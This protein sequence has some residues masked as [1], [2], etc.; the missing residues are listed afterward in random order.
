MVNSFTPSFPSSETPSSPS[1]LPSE[2]TV[3]ALYHF[4]HPLMTDARVENLRAEVLSHCQ[5]LNV[6]GTL[7]LAPEGINGT[8]SGS[9]DALAVLADYLLQQDEFTGLEYKTSQ[10]REG[11]A[12]F[13]RMKVKVK[14][15]I[16]S[17]GPRVSPAQRTGEHVDAQRFN[18]LLDDPDVVV[19]DTRNA[20]E[21]EVGTFPGALNPQ[22]KTFREFP[23]FVEQ[24][25][26]PGS[27][28]RVAMFCTGGIRCEKAAAYLLDQGFESVY[29]LD[30]GVLKYLETVQEM[31]VAS[32]ADG[33]STNRWDGE[34]FVFDQRVAL[35]ANLK[36]G[37]YLQCH[38]CRR[39]LPRS[40]ASHPDYK[41]GVSCPRC[42]NEIDATQRAG[43]RE[44]QKQMELARARGE[45]H[46]G[47][48]AQENAADQGDLSS[49]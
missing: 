9:T 29:Q 6:L 31:P 36:P 43:F 42:I 7:L 45:T 21:V 48:H 2:L 38:A 22:T 25:L 32:A 17:F 4:V 10:A 16:V 33:Q 27:Q 44:R 5:R 23:D 30:G 12:A 49:G 14:D 28:P 37:D 8:V 15:E 41:L 24:N 3:M 40:Q 18:E 1:E 39:P 26:D 34:C 19:V 47:P 13:L 46:I 11:E 20:Y 35:D